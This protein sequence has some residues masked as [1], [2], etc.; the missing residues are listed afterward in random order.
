MGKKEELSDFECGI[1][2]GTR[3]PDLSMSET[4]YLLGFLSTTIFTENE[5]FLMISEVRQN[6]ENTISELI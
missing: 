2:V 5:T 6:M 4:V 3:C 1:V